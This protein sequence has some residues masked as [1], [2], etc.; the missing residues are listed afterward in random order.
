[1]EVCHLA[2]PLLGANQAFALPQLLEIDS[3]CP[4]HAHSNNLF[5][6]PPL[7]IAGGRVGALAYPYQAD[8]CWQTVFMQSAYLPIL[9][10]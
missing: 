10:F 3:S 7:T 5:R 4:F 9:L 8:Y 1:M 2:R 6:G